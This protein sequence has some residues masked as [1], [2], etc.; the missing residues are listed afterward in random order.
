VASALAELKKS[1]TFLKVL[2][3]YPSAV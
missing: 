2:G 3:S 1:A